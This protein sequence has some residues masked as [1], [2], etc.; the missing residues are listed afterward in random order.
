MKGCVFR[1]KNKVLDKTRQVEKLV[2]YCERNYFDIT[3]IKVKVGLGK[4]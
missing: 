3:A 1:K 2:N 4:K